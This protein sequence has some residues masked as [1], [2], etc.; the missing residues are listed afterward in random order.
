MQNLKLVTFVLCIVLVTQKKLINS[1]TVRIHFSLVFTFQEMRPQ[2]VNISPSLTYSA[3]LNLSDKEYGK[4]VKTA[5]L[6]DGEQIAVKTIT[7][8]FSRNV[9]KTKVFCIPP[10]ILICYY[11]PDNKPPTDHTVENLEFMMIPLP[12]IIIMWLMA[13]VGIICS[14]GFLHF[15]I[16]KR[17]SR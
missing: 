3:C 4:V 5:I 16:S 15:N 1:P 7:K 12:L 11:F 17:K 8:T 10:N 6:M 14:L 2:L 9:L 13:A